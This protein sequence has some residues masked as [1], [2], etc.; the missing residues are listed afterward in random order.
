MLE[1]QAPR[2]HPRETQNQHSKEPEGI[3]SAEKGSDE[4]KEFSGWEGAKVTLNAQTLLVDDNGTYRQG[5]A[6]M[7]GQHFNRLWDYP[8]SVF[9]VSPFTICTFGIL[10]SEK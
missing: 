3:C 5:N 8:K 6:E 2:V 10:K 4:G 7:V 9:F 1:G